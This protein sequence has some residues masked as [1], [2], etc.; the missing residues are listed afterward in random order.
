MKTVGSGAGDARCVWV[1]DGRGALS[2]LFEFQNDLILFDP[3][4]RL[5]VD[6]SYKAACTVAAWADDTDLTPTRFYGSQG[7]I[8][9]VPNEPTLLGKS[10]PDWMGCQIVGIRTNM[11]G[12]SNSVSILILFHPD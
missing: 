12:Y 8:A 10:Q 3:F 7:G 9:G 6:P 1:G 4:I 11:M 5:E 2:Y